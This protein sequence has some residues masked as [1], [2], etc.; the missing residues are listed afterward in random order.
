MQATT[1]YLGNLLG[2]DQNARMAIRE[3]PLFRTCSD[4]LL[5]L[6]FRYGRIFSLREGETLTREGEFDQWVYFVIDGRLEVFVDGER[7]DSITSSLVGERCILG[8]PRRA[9]LK[10]GAEGINALGVDMAL[11]DALRDPAHSQR[12]SLTVYLELLG[13]IVGE[14]VQR[15]AEMEFNRMGVVQKHSIIL[16]AVHQSD[17]VEK[18][19]NNAFQEDKAASFAI[20]RYLNRHEPVLLSEATFGDPFDVDTRRIYVLCMEWG[21]LDVLFALADQLTA[22]NDGGLKVNALKGGGLNDGG[23]NDGGAAKPAGAEGESGQDLDFSHFLKRA[24]E[25]ILRRHTEQHGED[26]PIPPAELRL[27]F[28]LNYDFEIDLKGL[29]AWL[30]RVQGYAE[31]ELAEV[32]MVLLREVSAYTGQVNAGMKRLLMELKA[33]N[34]IKELETTDERALSNISDFYDTTPP[35]DLIPFFSKNILE[36]HL[37]QPYLD[38]L[39]ELGEPETGAGEGP[40]G[41]EG[42]APG[43]QGKELLDSL[44]D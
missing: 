35:E 10:A 28:T 42:A 39:A 5:E 13:R 16:K 3:I 15:V 41:A 21:R 18:F 25:A 34:F 12:N 36:V 23:L 31:K 37:I 43:Q 11:L 2:G 17:M 1:N 9:T 6:V 38:A 32:L 4:E 33:V 26:A 24:S 20:H 29:A 8:E 44:F 27:F 40:G 22:L 30:S 7:V 14:I 19:K